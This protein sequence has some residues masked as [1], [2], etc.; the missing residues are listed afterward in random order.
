M[1]PAFKPKHAGLILIAGLIGWLV[2][3]AAFQNATRIS[4]VETT[5]R[6][7]LLYEGETV[8]LDQETRLEQS[9]TATYPGL[10]QIDI[11]FKGN[12]ASTGQK[13]EFYLKTSC[14]AAGELVHLPVQLPP[15]TNFTF[16]PFQFSPIDDSAGQTYCIVLQAPD[17][18][19]G[20]PIELQLSAGDLYPRGQLK[21]YRDRP[22]KGGNRSHSDIPDN[23]DQNYKI[24][25]PIIY[26]QP[27]VNGQ[28]R[29]DDIGFRLHYKGLVGPTAHVFLSRLVANK[30]G[31]WGARWFYGG[32]VA[33][34]IIFLLGLFYV[35]Q[36]TIRHQ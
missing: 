8:Q 24:Y 4:W 12:N 9:F 14:A 31:I 10:S 5:R 32:L 11:L 17:V 6:K 30:P 21:I 18:S 27:F 29:A 19:P 34:Y 35:V 2:Y 7:L 28:A 13:V 1:I 16:S 15:N 36:K 20:Q 26:A 23:V 3:L 22:D 25:L 33:L